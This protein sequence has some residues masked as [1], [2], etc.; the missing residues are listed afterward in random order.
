VKWVAGNGA[1]GN[2]GVAATVRQVRGGI[3]YVE[4]AYAHTN[5]L[6]TTQLRNKSGHFVSATLDT[7]KAAA[8]RGDWAGSANFAVSLIDLDGENS[9]PIVSA[10]FILLPK[11]PTDVARSA[12]VMK[13]FDWAFA[14][15]GDLATQLDYIVLPKSVQDAVRAAWKA[16]IKGPN[17]AAVFN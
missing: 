3:G 12:N 17:G 2:D 15:G 9:W 14:N 13:F 8:D 5:K 7:F 1:K 4:Y 11:N 6:T 16:Q 10:T